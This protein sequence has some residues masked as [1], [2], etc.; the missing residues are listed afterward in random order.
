MVTLSPDHPVPETSHLPVVQPQVI[1][2]PDDFISL[3]DDSCLS[4]PANRVNVVNKH[5]PLGVLYAKAN[6]F[7]NKRDG[8]SWK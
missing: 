5:S 7:L 8:N 4:N 3:L 6:Q 1:S 2:L